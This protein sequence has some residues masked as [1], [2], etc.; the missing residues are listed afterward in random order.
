MAIVSTFS[1]ENALRALWEWLTQ[2]GTALPGA[3]SPL[4]DTELVAQTA[5]TGTLSNVADTATSTLI[6]AAN[7]AR[8]G[9]FVYNDS[10]V[11]LYLKLGATASATSFT[12]K[13]GPQDFF[14][15]PPAPVYTGIIDGI[16]ASDASGSARITE[17]T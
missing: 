9:A 4:I 12:V 17:L 16:W 5:A 7:T 2:G 15:L 3:T 14:E 1:Q 13:L 8:K 6:L 10:T 11:D